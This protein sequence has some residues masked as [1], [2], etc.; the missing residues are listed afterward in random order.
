MKNNILL[1]ILSA[2]VLFGCQTFDTDASFGSDRSE[3][4]VHLDIPAPVVAKT[5]AGITDELSSLYVLVFDKNGLYLSKHNGE[6][7]SSTTTTANYKFGSIPTTKEDELLI[8]HFVANYDWA[9][10]SDAGN[11]GK[12]EA[13]VMNTLTVMGGTVAYWQ[14][15]ELPNGLVGAKNSTITLTDDVSLLRNIAKITVTN[16][17]NEPVENKYLTDVSFAVGGYLDR[18]T[19]APY[20]TSQYGFIK[21]AITEALDGHTVPITD[22]SEF[23]AAQNGSTGSQSVAKNIY[24]RK[25]STARDQTYV[26]LKGY[27]QKTPTPSN[28]T[29]MSYYKIDLV[30][31]YAAKELL[32]IERNYHYI[33][34]VNN[35]AMEGYST[36]QEAIDNPASNN[37]NA[38]IQ[39]AE[40]TSVSDGTYVLQVEKTTFS[41]VKPGQDFQINYSY[42]DVLTGTVDNSKV[43]VTLEQDA[44]MK[45]IAD[46]S[47]I[48]TRNG[49]ISARTAAI[50]VNNDIYQATFIV[51][52]INS[53]L[54][55]R[56]TVRL[57][58][59]MNFVNVSSTP[60]NGTT[61][62]VVANMVGQPVTITFAFPPDISPTVFPLP[63]YVYS[64]KLSPDPTKM[65][66]DAL[67]I[68]PLP[69]NTFRYVYMAPY[70]GNDANDVPYTHTIY[71][72][73]STTSSNEDVI[74]TSDYF[75][76]V[77][78]NLR[79]ASIPAL[80]NVS[81]NPDPVLNLKDEPVQLTFDIP[82]VADN[83]QPYHIRIHTD[84][85]TYV[86]TPTGLDC[87]WDEDL[88]VY[89]Y[90]TNTTGS[91]RISFKTKQPES[92]EYVRIDGDRFAAITVRR[93]TLLGEFKDVSVDV[94]GKTAG[95]AV[96]ITLSFDAVGTHYIAG[97]GDIYFKTQY[98]TPAVGSG[99]VAT[100]ATNE[101]KMSVSSAGVK[102][103]R[104]TLNKDLLVGE[105]ETI[106]ISSANFKDYFAQ[107]ITPG[108][109][110]FGSN[111]PG[112]ENRP[113]LTVEDT[114]T[115]ISLSEVAYWETFN[116]RFSI[117]PSTRVN[118][119]VLSE[120]NPLYVCF[121][122]TNDLYLRSYI[123]ISSSTPTTYQNARR[124]WFKITS[125]GDKVVAFDANRANDNSVLTLMS[126]KSGET[127][128]DGVFETI[129][130]FQD[131]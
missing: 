73:S 30:D 79:S 95:S 56:V 34:Q 86:S 38:A 125:A 129:S 126:V 51:S 64:K 77:T 2:L 52:A 14:R 120:S 115:P 74:L 89:T 69:N 57:R 19:V 84:Y 59:P 87:I 118:G 116:L 108:K 80:S 71:L 15:I 111:V 124:I 60:N 101:Y 43:I 17:T 131:K 12:S 39:V 36:L 21:G 65:G 78:I 26:I 29:R 53:N 10:F 72:V 62:C 41:F 106:K 48:D 76:D 82:E 22:E 112:Y 110:S 32:D 127:T 13:E 81:F 24:E 9:S 85:L 121:E 44:A 11:V 35:V 42:Y 31:S 5:R 119:A 61:D 4:M 28:N 93:T 105:V 3:L 6:L 18:G 96:N 104:F 20:S 99:I 16:L 97:G 103:A 55:R 25:N 8:L 45:V 75:N 114:N 68:D 100:G 83:T 46:G 70:K 66:V 128:S 58:K 98:L 123:G 113:V 94:A 91:Q 117:P 50:P 90:T 1:V 107:N 122:S 47:F 33:I 27:Y 23:V 40:Y 109:F 130:G 37:I 92:S 7:V 54:S 49:I 63:V 67:S 102:T 88:G